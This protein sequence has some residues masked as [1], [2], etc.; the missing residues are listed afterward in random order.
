MAI[1]A[2]RHCAESAFEAYRQFL[3]TDPAHVDSVVQAM[4]DAIEPEDAR[5]GRM[6][7]EETGCGDPE[8][9]RVKDLMKARGTAEWLRDVT[10]LGM[11]EITSTQII[12]S[13]EPFQAQLLNKWRKGSLLVPGRRWGSSNAHRRPISPLRPT[14]R[15]RRRR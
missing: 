13:V 4:A 14:R 10:T 11:P 15:R 7:H 8:A 5:L 1:A 9:K 6:A 3:G 12:T 2:A